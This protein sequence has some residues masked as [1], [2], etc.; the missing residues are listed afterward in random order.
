MCDDVA[1]RVAG[2]PARMIDRDATEDE[3]DPVLEGMGVVT[4]ANPKFAHRSEAN[5]PGSEARSSSPIAAS[6]GVGWRR[7][8]GP[9]RTWIAIIPA[10]AAGSTSLST[11]SPTY[12]ISAGAYPTSS[13]TSPKKA[14]SGLRTPR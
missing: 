6:G 12:A 13:A 9:R 11:R 7:P 10:A 2:Q 4:E 14:G 5:A 8:H 3:R 1:V